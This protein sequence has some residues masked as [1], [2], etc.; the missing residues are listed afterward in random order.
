MEHVYGC[1][2]FTETCG[3]VAE[4]G[5]GDQ[6]VTVKPFGLKVLL[7]LIQLRFH[8]NEK[9]RNPGKS[10]SCIVATKI[11]LVEVEGI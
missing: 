4:A 8:T 6:V 11:A 5:L 9:A 10:H 7:R 1:R 2:G 3:Q